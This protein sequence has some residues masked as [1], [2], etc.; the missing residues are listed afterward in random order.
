MSNKHYCHLEPIAEDIYH[1]TSVTEHY[2]VP[3][4]DTR[5][6]MRDGHDQF[7]EVLNWIAELD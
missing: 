2:F 4:A 1:K 7:L 3:A 6:L 5:G